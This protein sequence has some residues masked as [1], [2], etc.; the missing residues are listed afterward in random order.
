MDLWDQWPDL[1]VQDRHAPMYHKYTHDRHDILGMGQKYSIGILPDL[2]KSLQG[3]VV[4][5]PSVF[6]IQDLHALQD[7]YL[8]T[9]TVAESNTIT[10]YSIL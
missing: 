6:L 2:P 9:S 10:Q 5:L 4:V 1:M 8:T 3:A 7:T